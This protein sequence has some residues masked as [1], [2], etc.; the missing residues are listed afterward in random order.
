MNNFL[1]NGYA[2]MGRFPVAP[3]NQAV[4][5]MYNQQQTMPQQMQ[6]PVQQVMPQQVSMAELPI[7]EIKFLNANQIKGY[8][9]TAGTKSLLIDREKGL[10]HLVGADYSANTQAEI[11]KFESYKPEEE[12][13]VVAPVLDD[14]LYVKKEELDTL[15]EGINRK[16]DKLSKQIRISELLSEDKPT[17][18]PKKEKEIDHE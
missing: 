6:Q 11:F 3:Y 5:S 1:N 14:K 4:M 2:G 18:K 16:I 12:K 8:I 15:F 10:A 9:P 13:P 7:T 17:E